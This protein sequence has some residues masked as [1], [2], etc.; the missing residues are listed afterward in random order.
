M[1][2]RLKKNTENCKVKS[3]KSALSP[4]PF[5]L[6]MLFILANRGKINSLEAARAHC[7]RNASGILCGEVK[8]PNCRFGVSLLDL[9]G[10]CEQ[11]WSLGSEMCRRGA[12]GKDP[13]GSL[14]MPSFFQRQR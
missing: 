3:L 2:K 5:M 1:D 10:L 9:Q 11:G 4:P 7:Y 6:G 12:E 13:W 14:L 8:A